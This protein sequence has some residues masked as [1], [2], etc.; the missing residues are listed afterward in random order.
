MK[1]ADQTVH[2]D[3]V[4]VTAVLNHKRRN[5]TLT[6]KTA[7]FLT[8]QV[9]CAN[10]S[11]GHVRAA[12]TLHWPDGTHTDGVGVEADSTTALFS[13]YLNATFSVSAKVASVHTVTCVSSLLEGGLGAE[14]ATHVELRCH[15]DTQPAAALGTHTDQHEAAWQAVSDMFTWVLLES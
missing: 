9:T 1:A 15:R 13:A 6:E 8:R 7:P 2:R 4:D 5:G 14:P 3:V 12:V 11:D 10:D